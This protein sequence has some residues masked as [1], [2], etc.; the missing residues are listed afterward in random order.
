MW[1]ITMH[2]IIID[3][4]KRLAEEPETGHNRWHPDILPILEVN[5]GDEVILETRDCLD[6]QLNAASTESAFS[7]ID[8]GAV[9]PL[10]GPVM[11]KGAN[12]GDLLEVEFLDIE[13]EP[14]GFSAIMPGMGFLRDIFT[15][16]FMVHWNIKDD[17]ATSPQ[18]PQ[19]KL[20]A[21][22]FMGVSGVAPSKSQ[23]DLYNHRE[24]ELIKRG[25][26]ALPPDPAGAVPNSGRPSLE[27]LRTLPPRENGGNLDIKQ[28]TKGAKLFLPVSVEGALFSTGDAH[29]TQGDGEVCVMGVEMSATVSLRFKV[30]KDAARKHNIVWPRFSRDGYYANPEWAVPKR[31]IATTGMPITPDGENDG[32]N[33]TLA[34]RNALLHMIELLS[35]RGFTR[36]QAYILCSVAADLKIGNVVDVP[37]YVVSAVLSEDIFQ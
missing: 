31:F 10:T 27:G 9:H 21:G 22:A 32:E 20:P 23:L 6:G 33:L 34:A 14:W 19:V 30:I 13:P 4:T 26:E 36:E 17:W 29:F 28:L 3:R 37:N 2:S 1:R 8:S 7:N 15:D 25:G 16:P 11:I 18:I 5:P 12:P 35:E 24:L